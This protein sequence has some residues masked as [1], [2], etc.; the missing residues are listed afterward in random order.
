[1]FSLVNEANDVFFLQNGFYL[2]N[3]E[4][5]KRGVGF[6]HNKKV[7]IEHTNSKV[8]KDGNFYIELETTRTTH[9]KSGILFNKLQD[10][11]KI[12]EYEKKIN[13]NSDKKRFWQILH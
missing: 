1:M 10:V 6:D 13:L 2:L 8:D 11:G 3:G 7:E 12:E 4:W 9:I 5:K